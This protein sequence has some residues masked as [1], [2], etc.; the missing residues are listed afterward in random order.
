MGNAVD[1]QKLQLAR[2]QR[3][4]LLEDALEAVRMIAK[5]KADP[6]ELCKNVLSRFDNATEKT[7][8]TKENK[9]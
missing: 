5:G 9:K 1:Q 6:V 7:Q 8:P 2:V 4:L 3:Y